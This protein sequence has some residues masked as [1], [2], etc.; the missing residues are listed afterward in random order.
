MP[1]FDASSP[2]GTEGGALVALQNRLSECAAYQELTGTANAAA[3]VQTIL[4]GPGVDPWNGDEW[5]REQLEQRH[6]W[7]NAFVPVDGAASD[8]EGDGVQEVFTGGVFEVVIHW[9]PAE[10]D[11]QDSRGDCYTFF[12]DRTGAIRKQLFTAVYASDPQCPR[13]RS[14]QRSNMGWLNR[15]REGCEGA[16]LVCS[17]AVSWGDTEE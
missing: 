12:L 10:I 6:C 2:A 9:K 14:V 11:L 3:A 17:L 8:F 13:I 15:V 5:T 16:G 7:S 4:L 1:L